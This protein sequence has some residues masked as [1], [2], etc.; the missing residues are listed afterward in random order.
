M[1]IVF[2]SWIYNIHQKMVAEEL[3]ST[4]GVNYTFVELRNLSGDATK[5]GLQNS[6]ECPFVLQAW[7]G[8]EE[9]AQAME[10]A[11]TAD[12]C[13]FASVDALP[14]QKARMKCNLLSFDMSERWLKQGW[15][16]VLSPAISKMFLAYWLGGWKNK[17]MYKLCCSAFAAGDHKKL[18]MYQDKC[19]KW[20]Y[21]TKVEMSG[22]E[23]NVEASADVSTSDIAPLM[24]CSRYLMWKHPELP[25]LLA[26]RLKKA[27]YK[28]HLDMYGEGG[29]KK[30]AIALAEELG[31]TDMVSF[32]GNKPNTVLMEDM[33]KHEIFLFTSD[34]NEGWGAVANESM[35]NGCVL[36]AS[37]TIGSTP[38]LVSEGF[39]GFVFQS[40]KP[41]CCF[42]NPDIAALDSL[43][44]KVVWLLEHPDERKQMQSNAMRVMQDVW[45]PKNAANSLLQLIRDLQAGRETSIISG[46]C[47]KA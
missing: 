46:P 25:V 17:P 19:Y 13:V 7:K 14:Y 26:E 24:W 20:G 12:V 44:E 32:I 35:S 43:Y 38:Y 15:K 29:Y 34:R 39:N 5:G 33:K 28:F 2:Y 22:C 47:S 36:V 10:L 42:K 1:K 27:G 41:S 9:A 8:E 4:P 16:N 45:S 30:Q 40:S 6:S 37:D 18:G 21:F 23:T 31:V 3:Y 11:V